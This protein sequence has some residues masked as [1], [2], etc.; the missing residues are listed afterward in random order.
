MPIKNGAIFPYKINVLP[1]S[2]FILVF[3]AIY[4]LC[5]IFICNI[6]LYRKPVGG[7]IQLVV[8]TGIA[9]FP[10][11]S[12]VY[13]YVNKEMRSSWPTHCKTVI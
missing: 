8:A 9:L 12:W 3:K 7:R 11:I 10:F 6:C 13:I 2:I 5:C 1:N 4:S